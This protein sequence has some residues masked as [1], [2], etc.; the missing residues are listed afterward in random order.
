MEFE[1]YRFSREDFSRL[2]LR[3]YMPERTDGESAVILAFLAAHLEEFDAVTFAKRVGTG[4]APN[5]DHPDAVQRGTVFSSMLRM[6]ILAVRGSRPV[7]IECK[8]RVTP[9]TLGQIK[10]YRFHFLKEHPDAPEPELL[11]V[12]RTATPDALEALQAEGITVYL[13]PDADVARD[14]QGKRV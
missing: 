8:Q 10:T 13:Y 5:P 1:G 6:D 2:L 14:A 3:R 7:I 12:G 11:V 4:V 9:A